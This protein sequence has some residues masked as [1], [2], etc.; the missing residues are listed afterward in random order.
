MDHPA[1]LRIF[2][3]WYRATHPNS[4]AEDEAQMKSASELD[5]NGNPVNP[6]KKRYT[7]YRRFITNRQACRLAMKLPCL[8]TSHRS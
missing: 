2:S 7:E 8:L 1:T 6:M 3:D 4:A 5:A